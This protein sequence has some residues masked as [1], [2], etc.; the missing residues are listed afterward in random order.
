[1]IN[2]IFFGINILLAIIIWK[3][4][5]QPSILDHYRDKLF[6]LR[7]SVRDFYISKNIPLE[8]KTYKNLRNLINSHLRFIEK[9]SFSKITYFSAQV[10]KNKELGNR[11]KNEL[12]SNFKTDNSELAKFIKDI[13]MNSV[14]IL[15]C[16]MIF[17][18]MPILI[19]FVFVFALKVIIGF[20][21]ATHCKIKNE[22]DCV[23]KAVNET[24][25]MMGKIV[26]GKD[27]EEFSYEAFPQPS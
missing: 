26:P 19:L 14:E 13:R 1:M 23:A 15:I 24:S 4:I 11:I 10:D 25:E 27:L 5:L 16:Y 12:N 6:D 18:S 9:M 21:K 20:V 22:F 3:Y 8:D 7:E 2:T 17:S